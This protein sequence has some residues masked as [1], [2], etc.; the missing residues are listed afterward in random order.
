MISSCKINAAIY[1]ICLALPRANYV[2]EAKIVNIAFITFHI[3]SSNM[4]TCTHCTRTIIWLLWKN[5]F[6]DK[7]FSSTW[8]NQIYC[9]LNKL[10]AF[11]QINFNSCGNYCYSIDTQKI[12]DK[13]FLV[14]LYFFS[15]SHE[16]DHTT[17]ISK[18]A[19]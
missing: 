14:S 19:I 9:V 3:P 15:N 8:Y 6:P 16:I 17:H 2:S 18:G 12:Q 4:H 13:S 1:L 7:M 11:E 10:C 5:D